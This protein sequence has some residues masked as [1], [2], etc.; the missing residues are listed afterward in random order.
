MTSA[1]SWWLSFPQNK[2]VQVTIMLSNI[3]LNLEMVKFAHGNISTQMT[4]IWSCYPWQRFRPKLQ[5]SGHQPIASKL[6]GNVILNRQVWV[7]VAVLP[8]QDAWLCLVFFIYV[9]SVVFLNC[10]FQTSSVLLSEILPHWALGWFLCLVLLIKVLNA[11]GT[12][13]RRALHPCYLEHIVP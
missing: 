9:K 6:R 13:L 8:I 4:E 7:T 3:L 11:V 5:C 1:W 2:H 10:S 12:V